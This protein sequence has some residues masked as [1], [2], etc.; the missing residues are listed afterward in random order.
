MAAERGRFI[1]Q[2]Q[3]MNLFMDYPTHKKLS[4]I[5]FILG[6]RFENRNILLTN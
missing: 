2:S 3:Y 1:D 5:H 4:G 6:K